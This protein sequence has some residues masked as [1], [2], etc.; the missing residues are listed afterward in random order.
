MRQRLQAA[1][2]LWMNLKTTVLHK[3]KRSKKV[4]A[5]T[6]HMALKSSAMTR[7]EQQHLGFVLLFIHT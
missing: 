5:A 4:S 6:N 7:K 1:G 2:L 3:N